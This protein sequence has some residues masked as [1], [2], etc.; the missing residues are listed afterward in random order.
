LGAILELLQL[1]ATMGHWYSG[2][3]APGIEVS[4]TSTPRF[5]RFFAL[6]SPWLDRANANIEFFWLQRPNDGIPVHIVACTCRQASGF[7]ALTVGLGASID[8]EQAMYSALYETIPISY[9]AMASGLEHLYEYAAPGK[10]HPERLAK[11]LNEAYASLD[12]GNILDLD[13]GVGYYALPANTEKIIPSRFDSRQ[14]VGGPEIRRQVQAVDKGDFAT[15]DA[16]ATFLVSRALQHYRLFALDFSASDSIAL[17]FRIV[18]LF[19]PDLLALSAPSFPEGAHPR[20][21]AYG[22]FHTSAPHPYP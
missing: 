11:N 19:S 10:Q 5:A 22:G 13:S 17:G 12:S 3:T 21:Q 16:L 2:S 8:L 7:P 1:D 4:P 18:R 6:Y 9:A 15:P 14:K 20:Y